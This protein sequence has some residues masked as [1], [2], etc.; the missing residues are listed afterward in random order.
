MN[1]LLKRIHNFD[2][3]AF[4]WINLEHRCQYRRTV[5]AISRTADG[6]LYILFGLTVLLLDGSRGQDFFTTAVCAYGLEVVL[7]LLFKN[8]IK[9]DRPSVSLDHFDAWIVPS[10][11]FSFPSGHTAAAFVFA[12]MVAN[13]Y[14]DFALV[15]LIWAVL[16][17]LSRV[18]QGVHYP[19][20]IIAGAALGIGCAY[21]TLS[22][23]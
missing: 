16:V 13:F 6:P 17:G 11:K 8:T 22:Y 2:V 9:R 19:S 5:R 4:L 20:D 23:I 15:T 14:P 3:S 18:I 1:I 12:C 10:D 21:L 7:Y